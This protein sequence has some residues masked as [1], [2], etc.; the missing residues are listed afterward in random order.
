MRQVPADDDPARARVLGDARDVEQLARVVLDAGQE[1]QG[2][3]VGVGVD[4]GEDVRGGE[5]EGGRVV[6][7]QFD[8]GGGGREVVPLELGGDRVLLGDRGLVSSDC[9]EEGAGGASQEL[10]GQEGNVR[11]HWGRASTLR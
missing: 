5:G 2:G 3:G 8:E 9:R 1:E 4:G 7:V 11:S 6:W 10:K